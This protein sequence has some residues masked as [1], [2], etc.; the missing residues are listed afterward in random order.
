MTTRWDEAKHAC[1]FCSVLIFIMQISELAIISLLLKWTP[2]WKN[3]LVYLILLDHPKNALLEHHRFI[4][5]WTTVNFTYNNHQQMIMDPITFPST[6]VID[7]V[8][9]LNQHLTFK[10]NRNKLPLARLN[11]IYM[12]P[13]ATT[14]VERDLAW[15]RLA[16]T[17]WGR[18]SDRSTDEL[19]TEPT[20]AAERT[21]SPT[22]L[23]TVHLL[24]DK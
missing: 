11:E 23:P 9:H 8:R 13:L 10:I 24:P 7:C 16:R 18:N 22:G 19:A 1:V 3:A 6:L 15:N 17:R 2:K 20:F 12:L 14:W 21:S 4:I 5:S